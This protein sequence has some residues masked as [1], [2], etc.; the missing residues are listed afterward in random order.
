[1]SKSVL[2]GYDPDGADRA[3]VRFG[4]AI[5]RAT[6]APLVVACVS[7][8]ESGEAGDEPLSAD[9][10]QAL[11][12]VRDHLQA[13]GIE[14]ECRQ[15]HSTSAARALHEEAEHDD[16]GLLVVGSSPRRSP[17]RIL[18]GSTAERLMHGAPC[19]VAVVPPNWAPPRALQT[20]GV[21]F[22]ATP[23]G[24]EAL[25]GAHALARR[26]GARLRVLTVVRETIGLGLETE[27][28][29]P[30]VPGKSVLTVEGEHELVAAE[31]ARQA[32]E[33]LGDDGSAEVES[34]VGDPAE[35][36][37]DVSQHLDLLVCGSRGY[38]P[39][40]A[41]L[42]GGVSRQLVARA[43]C[44]VIALPRG[45]EAALEALL[46]EAPAAA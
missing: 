45:V 5:A 32:L 36:L 7:R 29:I 44:P 23:E 2:V 12:G 3:P 11:G 28:Y 17:Q 35:I 31:R 33:R 26:F 20:V 6:G 14:V 37:V 19:P 34:F 42:L 39:L 9:A 13:E 22:V 30:P 43:H 4:A 27:P 18:G 8:G 1:M 38:G 41:V 16:A 10:R 21:G 40:R 46:A 15:L 25:R 24:E